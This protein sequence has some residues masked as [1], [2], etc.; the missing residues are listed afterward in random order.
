MWKLLGASRGFLRDWENLAEG[1]FPA[2]L[3]SH[4]CRAEREV[5][6]QVAG[7]NVPNTVF[8]GTKAEAEHLDVRHPE[9]RPGPGADIFLRKENVFV[10]KEILWAE[11]RCFRICE[12]LNFFLAAPPP[13]PRWANP[14]ETLENILTI[15]SLSSSVCSGSVKILFFY[16]GSCKG[17]QWMSTSIWSGFR[18]SAFKLVTVVNSHISLSCWNCD[19]YLYLSC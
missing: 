4:I 15:C 9:P 14:T 7:H 5:I 6:W 16:G 18:E 3:P 12:Y 19:C 11:H 10:V 8:N 17:S 13:P 1:S 2:L